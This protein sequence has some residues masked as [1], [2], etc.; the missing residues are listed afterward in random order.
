MVVRLG[1]ADAANS[2][3]TQSFSGVGASAWRTSD[4]DDVGLANHPQFAPNSLLDGFADIR[5]VLEKLLGVLAALAQT[6]AAISKPRARFF[7][8]PLVHGEVDEI[9]RA[10]D[11]LAVHDVELGFPERR[12]DLVLHDLHARAA[13]DDGVTV[14][15]ARDA[16]DV[17]TH[18]RVELQRAA[19]G[20][21]L[22]VAEHHADFFAQLVDENEAGFRLRHDAGALPQRLRHEARLQ[23]HLRIAHLALDFCLR[24]ERGDRVD[25]DD[26]DASRTDEDFDDL[27]RLLAV[28]GL[29]HEQVLQIHTQLLRVHRIERVLRVDEGRHAAEF[30]RFGDH[31]QRQRGL[32]RRFRPED[33]HDAAAGH[34]ADAECVVDADGAGG[35]GF[36]GL[37]GALL[38]EA[39]DRP[40]AKLFFDLADR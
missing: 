34:A 15:D 40:F 39:H 21:R 5:V 18:R 6:L 25:H 17:E 11:A 32:A 26:V 19:A 8:D 7:D 16:A 37:N 14:L 35:N 28:V 22:R 9:A 36:D 23:T 27:Q 10:R 12:G 3:R 33:L 24:H 31:L 13:A 30:L 1:S 2:L 4:G 20:G 29:R 38:T